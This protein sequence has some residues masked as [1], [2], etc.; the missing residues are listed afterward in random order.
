MTDGVPEGMKRARIPVNETWNPDVPQNPEFVSRALGY[1]FTFEQRIQLFKLQEQEV[2]RQWQLEQAALP[3]E[4]REVPQPEFK[5]L[6][7][8][9]L[10]AGQYWSGARM[11][12]VQ[13]GLKTGQYKPFVKPITERILSLIHI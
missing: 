5:W 8:E 2:A 10:L 11:S 12:E 7:L 6:S 3:P 9:A 1:N 4:Q 13:E